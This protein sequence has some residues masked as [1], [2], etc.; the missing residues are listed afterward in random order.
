M[1][2]FM[3]E[4]FEQLSTL[5]SAIRQMLERIELEPTVS[6]ALTDIAPEITWDGAL[7]LGSGGT[8]GAA[9]A[10]ALDSILERRYPLTLPYPFNQ[11]LDVAAA[12]GWWD[13]EDGVPRSTAIAIYAA[14]NS[15]TS[16]MAAFSGIGRGEQVAL[17]RALL[18]V[19]AACL[20][21]AQ[22]HPAHKGESA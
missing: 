10:A 14:P 8:L 2:N 7:I 13:P 3:I 17:L 15:N 4:E 21:V 9:F 1:V 6:I 12:E 19:A 11:L 22:G 5:T 16:A 18:E 20:F